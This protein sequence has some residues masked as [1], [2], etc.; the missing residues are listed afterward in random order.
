MTTTIR[1]VTPND[2]P[3]CGHII[4]EAFKT[5]QDRHGF[6]P[7]FPSVEAATDFARMLTTHPGIFGVVAEMEARTVASGFLWQRDPVRGIG[8]VTVDP[9]HQGQGTGRLVMNALL[10]RTRGVA[11][12]RLVQDAFNPC[13]FAL[14]ASLGFVVREPLMLMQGTPKSMPENK[15]D[16]SVRPLTEADIGACAAL[17][18]RIHGYDRGSELR[19]AVGFLKPLVVERGGRVRGYVTMPTFWPANHGVAETSEDMAALLWGAALRINA[20]LSLLVPTRQTEFL[21]WC[22]R[23]GLRCVKPM[24]LMTIGTYREPKGAYFPSV[25][26]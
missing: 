17:A 26:Y 22:L 16:T 19:D 14:Y 23:E 21:R 2:A 20:P 5:V 6:A 25:I 3:I 12:V 18:E 15:A 7:D 24:T 10:D 9:H 13:S 8:P 11:G 1:N 4:Y